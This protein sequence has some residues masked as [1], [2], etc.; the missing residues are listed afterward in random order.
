MS[1]KQRF[2]DNK[3]AIDAAIVAGEY[4]RDIAKRYSITDEYLLYNYIIAQYGPNHVSMYRSGQ[5]RKAITSAP[6]SYTSIDGVTLPAYV[7]AALLRLGLTPR[8]IAAAYGFE[9]RS[10]C[11]WIV[12]HKITHAVE[13]ER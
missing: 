12:Q 7:C 6:A 13:I 3:L 2:A 1:N 8:Q 10:L 11:A 4:R 9:T 5:A